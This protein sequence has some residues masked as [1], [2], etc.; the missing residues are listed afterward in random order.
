M[1]P[2]APVVDSRAEWFSMMISYLKIKTMTVWFNL[3]PES[4]YEHFEE[5]WP[6]MLDEMMSRA[7]RA[8]VEQLQTAVQ[9]NLN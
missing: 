4:T 5:A 9:T 8:A 1:V 6:F 7:T 3:H 2:V